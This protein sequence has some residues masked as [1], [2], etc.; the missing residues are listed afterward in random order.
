MFSENFNLFLSLSLATRILCS[1]IHHLS[2]NSYANSLLLYFV[3]GFK[4]LYGEDRVSY[5]VHVLLHLAADS[6]RLGVLDGFS[7]FKF[8]NKLGK[9]RKLIRSPYKPL[10]QLKYRLLEKG[11][12]LENSNSIEFGPSAPHS[13]GPI[14]EEDIDY[15]NQFRIFST[16][17]FKINCGLERDTY[18]LTKRK[19]L[20]RVL[21]ILV[22]KKSGSII[23]YGRQYYRLESLFSYPCSSK[24]VDIFRVRE[25]SYDT[26]KIPACASCLKCVVFPSSPGYI[27]VF[28]LIHQL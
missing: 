4:T 25:N 26:I 28:P 24:A 22:D 19:L 18:I 27:A 5:N 3:E 2:L 12:L 8:E 15:F 23:F 21:N 13:R 10:E 17:K 7:A 9:L 6:E 16:E 1:E 11:L 14:R 20:F